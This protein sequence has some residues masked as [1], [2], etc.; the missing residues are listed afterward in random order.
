MKTLAKIKTILIIL[1]ATTPLILNVKALTGTLEDSGTG[2]E[3]VE[4]M[5]SATT[6]AWATDKFMKNP[7]AQSIFISEE[8]YWLILHNSSDGELDFHSADLTD[9]LDWESEYSQISFYGDKLHSM[10]FDDS[11]VYFVFYDGGYY[12]FK[13]GT[14]ESDGTI[15][16]GSTEDCINPSGYTYYSPDLAWIT[17][18]K[19]KF[20]VGEQYASG[21]SKITPSI[22][23]SNLGGGSYYTNPIGNMQVLNM[24]SLDDDMDTTRVD[25]AR[26][27][28]DSYTHYAVWYNDGANWSLRGE[29]GNWTN[30]PRNHDIA[31]TWEH[32]VTNYEVLDPTSFSMVT[33]EYTRYSYTIYVSTGNVV[34]LVVEDLENQVKIDEKLLN[35]NSDCIGSN[36]VGLMKYYY[37]GAENIYC[38]WLEEDDSNNF[39]VNMKIYREGDVS[40]LIQVAN[41]TSAEE[42]IKLNV[43]REITQIE[44]DEEIY[45]DPK[46]FITYLRA[47]NDSANYD[48]MGYFWE[49][50]LGDE[51]E[52]YPFFED[53]DD[54]G[55]ISYVDEY[56]NLAFGVFGFLL[57]CY[58]G[59]RPAMKYRKHGINDDTLEALGLSFIMFI[60]GYGVIIIWLGVYA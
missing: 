41:Y 50:P 49:L 39:T 25:V 2:W 10:D 27:D 32:N 17:S 57:M 19:H 40:N 31:Y 35:D 18:T 55:V 60:I 36:A 33:N 14:L 24:D 56:F 16:L 34:R 21:T 3:I 22:D 8:K 5:D 9:P 13:R 54:N 12:F 42:I 47:D 26:A 15:T 46:G 45:S 6:E 11:Y 30:P 4:I 52:F 38:F 29:I 28:N 1:L 43:A 23:L 51:Y 58:A 37:N 53:D 44:L 20:F 7:N 59:V 48:L